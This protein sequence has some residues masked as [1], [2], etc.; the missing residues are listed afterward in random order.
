M[1]GCG[2]MIVINKWKE[3]TKAGNKAFEEGRDNTAKQLYLVACHRAVKMY[4]HW[5]DGDS[6]TAVLVISYQ[7]LGDLYLRQSN[8]NGMLMVYRDLLNMLHNFDYNHRFNT[9]STCQRIGTELIAK[10]K[11]V[12]Y[13]SIETVKLFNEILDKYFNTTNHLIKDHN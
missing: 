9:D 2:G 11:D 12:N 4:P 6:A 7:N 10:F 8:H 3:I 13:K 1:S 5:L